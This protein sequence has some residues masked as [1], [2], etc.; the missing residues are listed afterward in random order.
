[1]RT[2]MQTRTSRVSEYS[3]RVKFAITLWAKPGIPRESMDLEPL[4]VP[5]TQPPEQV[6][7]E[8]SPEFD[9]EPVRIDLFHLLLT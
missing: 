9:V 8:K 3:Q 7:Y 2:L 4:G 6:D 1:M 5:E